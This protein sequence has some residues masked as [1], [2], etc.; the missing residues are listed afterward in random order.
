MISKKT[1]TLFNDIE[2]FVSQS[3]AMLAS[4]AMMEMHGLDAQV[5]SLCELVIQLSQ[6]ER[7][8][9]S[10]RMQ[11]LLGEL[12]SLGESMVETRDQLAEEIRQLS[13]SK[14]AAHAYKIADSRDD[15]GKRA[16]DADEAE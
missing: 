11:H 9:A 14:K 6:E 7:I 13:H 5:R 12:K 3:R 15:Y 4:G 2:H 8:A 1:E 10:T 16:D